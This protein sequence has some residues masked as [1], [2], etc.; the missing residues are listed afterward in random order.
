MEW[1]IWITWWVI[2]C[3]RYS[4]LL[5]L[6]YQKHEALTDNPPIRIY[7]NQI[8]NRIW[9]NITTGYLS[10][11]LMPETMKLLRNTKTKITKDKN[12]KNVPH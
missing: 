10:P 3:I 4:R 8:E 9:F 2:F 5:W 1:R 11:T 6:Y 12:G 7:V